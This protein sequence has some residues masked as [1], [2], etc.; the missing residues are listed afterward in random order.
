MHPALSVTNAKNVIVYG[1]SPI[2]VCSCDTNETFS[3]AG[4]IY[5]LVRNEQRITQFILP[6]R[7]Q[8]HKP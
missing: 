3:I 2:E 8:L 1:S 7:L 6:Y 4:N 5:R